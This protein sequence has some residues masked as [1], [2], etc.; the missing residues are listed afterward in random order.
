MSRL[1][2]T[3]AHTVRTDERWSVNAGA[4]R[5]TVTKATVRVSKGQPGGGQFH[6]ATNLRGTVRA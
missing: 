3:V 5:V 4:K 1:S 6:G 2:T